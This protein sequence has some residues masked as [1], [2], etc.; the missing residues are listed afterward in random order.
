MFLKGYISKIDWF[1]FIPVVLIMV[2]GLINNYNYTEQ[3][4]ILFQKQFFFVVIS[5]II[6]LS[7]PFFNPNILKGSYMSFVLYAVSII[8]LLL[9]FTPIAPEINGAKSWF[10][11]G[12]F[13]IQPVDFIKIALIIILARYFAKRH[14][15]I[16]NIIHI[17]TSLILTLIIFVLVY[18]QPDFGSSI[19]FPIIWFCIIV[20][21]GVSMKHLLGILFSSI[22][23]FVFLFQFVFPTYQ[24]ERIYSF[25][26]PF[27]NLQTSGYTANQSKIAIGSGSFLGKGT[28]DGTQSK[29]GFLPLYQSDFAFAAYS[30]EHGFLGVSLLF[31]LY[32]FIGLRLIHHSVNGKTNFETLFIFGVF[33]LIFSHLLIHTGV[34]VNILPVTGTTMPFLSYGGSHLIAG[35]LV[36]AIVMSMVKEKNSEKFNNFSR[37]K[38]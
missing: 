8:V 11:I 38:N 3:G 19:I 31:L 30:E 6:L 29:L 16:R 35:A 26:A 10:D 32:F 9:L 5:I 20:A 27:A 18:K 4:I 24:K 33:V 25:F 28:G 7:S 1:L 2:T 23:L 37:L 21:S 34:N 17:I 36:I 14:V 15:H 12:I 13:L 22:L